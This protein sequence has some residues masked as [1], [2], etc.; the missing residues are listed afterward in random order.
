M[1][2]RELK[3][4]DAQFMLEW[5]HDENVT[6]DLNSDFSSKTIG[7]AVN[8]IQ[9]ANEDTENLHLA[10]VSDTDEYQGTVS[11]KKINREFED[12]EFA[13]T[14]RSCAMGKGYA[15][16]GMQAIIDKAFGEMALKRI[17]WCVSQ[18][19]IRAVKYYEKHLFKRLEKP[20]DRLAE[21]YAGRNDLIWYEVL[22]DKAIAE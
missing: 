5:M 14:V 15:W 13:I 11:L 18:N 3:E 10:I 20:G 19:N 2:I 16:Y 22:N 7:D 8:F 12:A 6:R 21:R 9:V 17:Y 4:K 1:K